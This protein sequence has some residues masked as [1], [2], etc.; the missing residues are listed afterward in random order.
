MSPME[1]LS[2]YNA[3]LRVASPEAS[4]RTVRRTSD[5]LAIRRY[6]KWCREQRIDPGSF[7][8]FRFAM[9]RRGGRF[10]RLSSLASERL[11]EHFETWDDPHL[12]REWEDRLEQRSGTRI[13]QLVRDLLRL[14]PLQEAVR[15]RR[16]LEG[17]VAL[18]RLVDLDITGG[19]DP[20]SAICPACSE[21]AGCAADAHKSIGFSVAHLRAGELGKL[22]PG[23]LSVVRRVS[24]EEE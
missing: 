3:L 23:I 24:S 1:G 4:P 14:A 7:M 15:H 10:P 2:L 13:E 19:Y 17:R 8:R 5:K 6:L 12:R 20:R 9:I 11:L 18:C 16:H 21:R 22:P